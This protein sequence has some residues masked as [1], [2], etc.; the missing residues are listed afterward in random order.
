MI[1]II[2]YG[3]G[4]LRSIEKALSACGV[5]FFVSNEKERLKSASHI[6]LPGVGFFK[7]GMNNLRELGLIEFLREEVLEKK[8]PILGICLGMQLLF[9][10]SEE[11]GLVEGLGFIKGNVKR[12]SF[13]TNHLKVPHVGWNAVFGEDFS[14]IKIFKDIKENSNFYFVHSYHAV[15]EEEVIFS[16]TDHGYNFVSAI[17]KDNIYGT[18]FHPEKSQENG[19]K[20]L[21]NFSSIGK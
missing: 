4:N 10:T 19:L 17:Q 15:P 20:I 5:D 12:F 13:K 1:A 21:K 3:M 9:E 7:E 14:K 2:D 6:I 11:G 8:K 16:F 18:Q